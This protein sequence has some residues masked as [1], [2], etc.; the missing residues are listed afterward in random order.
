MVD[1]PNKLTSNTNDEEIIEEEEENDPYLAIVSPNPANNNL[2]SL[3]RD[4]NC[5]SS[6]N[7]SLVKNSNGKRV[8]CE[9]NS[10]LPTPNN[11]NTGNYIL[12]RIG[13]IKGRSEL[14]NKVRILGIYLNK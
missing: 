3:N 5:L 6:P 14:Q 11:I 12:N 13:M 7:N 9:S 8:S 4:L 1:S 10:N 2:T